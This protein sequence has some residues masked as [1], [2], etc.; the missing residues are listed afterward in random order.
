VFKIE[1]F[2]GPE[3]RIDDDR[4]LLDAMAEHRHVPRDRQLDLDD[5][6]V[7]R[8]PVPVARGRRPE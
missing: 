5:P 6:G 2:P 1:Q 3:Q 8:D 7:A 4:R